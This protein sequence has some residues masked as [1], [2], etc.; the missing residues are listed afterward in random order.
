VVPLMA[1]LRHRARA[2]RKAPARLLNSSR[3]QADI[4]Y[5]A[6]LDRLGADG[7]GLS[8]FHTVTREKPPGWTGYTRR[9]DQSMLQEVA[10]PTADMP[11]V[12]ICG[13]TS[14]V[15]AAASLLVA[16]GYEPRSIKTER[17]G[18]TGG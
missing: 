9:L 16:L 13:P 11:A 7:D 14:F 4:I 15:E 2:A 1:M 12:F 17:F 8:V 18:A 10:W 5:R 3:T 6:E